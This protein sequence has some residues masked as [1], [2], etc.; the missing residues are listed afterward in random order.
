[1]E[2]QDEIDLFDD[3][4]DLFAEEEVEVTE[5]LGSD[6]IDLFDDLNPEVTAVSDD[7][8]NL[9]D[10]NVHG[11]EIIEV[12][13]FEGVKFDTLFGENKDIEDIDTEEFDEDD[14]YSDVVALSDEFMLTP[15]LNKPVTGELTVADETGKSA[16]R[17]KLISDSSSLAIDSNIASV[18]AIMAKTFDAPV[19]DNTRNTEELI[20]K[21]FSIEA[22]K[23]IDLN[24]KGKIKSIVDATYDEEF[25]YDYAMGLFLNKDVPIPEHIRKD[26]NSTEFTGFHNYV[27]EVHSM[28]SR[29]RYTKNIDDNVKTQNNEIIYEAIVD[30]FACIH[31]NLKAMIGGTYNIIDNVTYT[32]SSC[33]FTCGGCKE[34]ND[35]SSNIISF[36][37]SANSERR[38]GTI[39]LI[40]PQICNHCGTYNVLPRKGVT[41]LLGLVKDK[42]EGSILA[43]N[44]RLVDIQIYQPSRLELV[45]CFPD[46]FDFFEDA[47][48]SSKELTVDWGSIR[49]KFLESIKL[50]HLN[51][52]NVSAHENV[53]IRG[54]AKILATQ[55]DDYSELKSK[56]FSSIIQELETSKLSMLSRSY[57]D[58]LEVPCYYT[59]HREQYIEGLSSMINSIAF[60][61]NTKE[62][63]LD[64]FNEHFDKYCK[65]VSDY[66]SIRERFI[67]ELYTNSYIMSTLPISN[68]RLTGEMQYNYLSDKDLFK[69]LDYITD[70]MIISHTCE[71]FMKSFRPRNPK[72]TE[73]SRNHSY[74][75]RFSNIKNINKE[76]PAIVYIQKYYEFFE[77]MINSTYKT[78]VHLPCENHTNTISYDYKFFNLLGKF[79]RAFLDQ[80]YFDM[81]NIKNELTTSE[82]E[83]FN[84]MASNNMWSHVYEMIMELP[85]EHINV[86]KGEY[87]FGKGFNLQEYRK[88]I[89]LFYQKRFIPKVLEGETFIEKYNYYKNLE[90]SFDIDVKENKS[91]EE[92]IDKY[93][94]T[95]LALRNVDNS[96]CYDNILL[97]YFSKDFLLS[98][99]GLNLSQL[100]TV[101]YLNKEIAGLYLSSEYE[102]SNNDYNPKH[103]IYSCVLPNEVNDILNDVELSEETKRDS[104]NYLADNLASKFADI[105]EVETIIKDYFN[106]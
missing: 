12:D 3:E 56:A 64:L 16:T 92:Y 52:S 36:V 91:L 103:L 38:K 22:P 5:V 58:G 59:N 42:M 18:K 23:F 28:I 90:H 47:K 46:L 75:K 30:G 13:Q 72:T 55:C 96:I 48:V 10:T 65:F 88:L 51:K 41:K 66:S 98:L 21:V 60:N 84:K 76:K 54:L 37:Y 4:I 35:T 82:Y 6:E 53:D 25:D 70:L 33:K 63:N 44:N 17:A 80:D 73:P 39:P 83:T 100:C 27:R 31:K 11:E 79:S 99:V 87:Y 89:E 29:D 71:D 9:L 62:Y 32:N 34:V 24:C 97:Y 69:V 102:N 94:T 7:E 95:S 104:M 26:V 43:T 85:N 20:R 57:S 19:A 81:I 78:S 2:R 68:V 101:L 86:P 1:M 106:M 14:S 49:D 74:D 93:Y 50:I 8:I 40:A 105:P 67:G 61:H 45:E 77:D 15:Q